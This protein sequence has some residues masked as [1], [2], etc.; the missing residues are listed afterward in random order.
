MGVVLP[1]WVGFAIYFMWNTLCIHF[2]GFLFLV[3]FILSSLQG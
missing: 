2:P 3:S 1:D